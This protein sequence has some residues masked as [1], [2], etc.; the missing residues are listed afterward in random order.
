[1]AKKKISKYSGPAVAVEVDGKTL[2]V[3]PTKPF[4]ILPGLGKVDLPKYLKEQAALAKKVKAMKGKKELD[5]QA[6]NLAAD[7]TLPELIGNYQDSGSKS[8]LFEIST[9]KDG[10]S[11]DTVEEATGELD[12]VKARL[13]E[14]EAENATLKSQAESSETSKSED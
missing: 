14:L 10:F 9:K 8:S 11:P 1:M 5:A 3:R 13:A 12:E 7:L 4:A 2:Y 6:R